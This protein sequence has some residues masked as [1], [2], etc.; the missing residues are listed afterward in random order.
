[1]EWRSIST[2]LAFVICG[3]G[4]AGRGLIKKGD[5]LHQFFALLQKRK[6]ASTMT[7]SDRTADASPH[8]QNSAA[9]RSL[10]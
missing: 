2:T 10:R 5:F 1:M 3:Q 8:L 9:S 7:R 4:P 6:K